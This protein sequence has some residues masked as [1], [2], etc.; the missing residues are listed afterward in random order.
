V[1]T[2]L[3]R[4]LVGISISRSKWWLKRPNWSS[5][6]PSKLWLLVCGYDNHAVH[7]L[8]ALIFQTADLANGIR[9]HGVLLKMWVIIRF[10]MPETCAWSKLV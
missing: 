9:F 2:V 4:I 7:V 8:L 3:L 1:Q 10:L 5:G 6:N